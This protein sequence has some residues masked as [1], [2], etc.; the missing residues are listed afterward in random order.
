MERWRGCSLTQRP[1]GS[2]LGWLRP[3][4]WSNLGLAVVVQFPKMPRTPRQIGLALPE[5]LVNAN[6]EC[7]FCLHEFAIY[8][9]LLMD[10]LTSSMSSGTTSSKTT[11]D[12]GTWFI[13]LT[14]GR[15]EFIG[16]ACGEICFLV[17]RT[18]RSRGTLRFQRCDAT[19]LLIQSQPD[20]PNKPRCVIAARDSDFF[21]GR[22]E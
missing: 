20:R 2:R 15:G 11:L 22:T 13:P 18:R 9:E 12:A 3:L 14:L 10:T 4:D 8:P 7:C 16:A 5:F 1:H 19:G 21:Y 17:K 6:F